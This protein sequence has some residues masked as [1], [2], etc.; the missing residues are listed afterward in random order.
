MRFHRSRRHLALMTL[1][2]LAVLFTAENALTAAK[3]DIVYNIPGEP[4]T[5][6]PTYAYDTSSLTVA[7]NMFEGLL[8]LDQT[9]RPSPGMAQSWKISPDG[10]V[11]RF[12][13]REASW[14]DGQPVTAMDFAYAW[15]RALT[16]GQPAE[17]TPF[18]FVLANAE[19]YHKGALLD[20][21]Q[22]GVKAVDA[23]TL[24]VRLAKP[25][26]HFLTLCCLPPFLPV[27]RRVVAANPRDWSLFPKTSISNGPFR[28]VEYSPQGHVMLVPNPYYWQKGQ[29]RA[30]SVTFTWLKPAEASSA[31]T[32]GLL[33]GMIDPP[34]GLRGQYLTRTE[35]RLTYL[36]FNLRKPPLDQLVVRNA[37]AAA[38]NRA[39]FVAQAATTDMPAFAVVPPGLPDVTI[40]KDFRAAGGGI[41]F[42]DRDASL[43]RR[44][45]SVAGLSGGTGLPTLDLVYVSGQ[46]NQAFANMVVSS[47]AEVGVKVAPAPV[48]WTD[49]QRRLSAGEFSLAR[50]GWVADYPDPFSFLGLFASGASTNFSA[51]HSVTYDRTLAEAMN[52]TDTVRRVEAMHRA[53]AILANDL[54]LVP[55]SFGKRLYL[56][57]AHLRD[58]VHLAIGVPLFRLAWMAE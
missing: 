17:H 32:A 34:E 19:A 13:L 14:S 10:L 9:H 18:L 29:T 8:R 16:P 5:L 33:D 46:R 6:D 40:G 21:G 44:L 35:L 54:P 1:L 31:Y 26:G 2:V 4:M 45:L 52:A 43:S 42:A 39:D 49:Y 47:L 57:G 41:V 51:Y 37:I 38:L 11:Y 36:L 30:R 22:V 24:E 12:T 28:L 7:L 48:S 15:M 27:N 25:T 55:V 50:V 56:E 3:Q 23:R 58:V 20:P 53:E